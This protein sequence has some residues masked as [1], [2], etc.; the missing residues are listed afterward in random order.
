MK[1]RL[2]AGWCQEVGKGKVG[3]KGRRTQ[4]ETPN[5][6]IFLKQN[7]YVFQRDF[8]TMPLYMTINFILSESKI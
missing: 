8:K 4:E 2:S 5:K 6:K 3:D 7:I 1:W